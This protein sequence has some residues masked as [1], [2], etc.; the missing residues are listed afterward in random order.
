MASM[1]ELKSMLV[2]REDE[3]RH[4]NELVYSLEKELDEKDAL[5]RHLKN[6]IDKF[7]QVVRPLT[8]DI[9]YRKALPEEPKLLSAEHRQKRQAISAEPVRHGSGTAAVTK[10]PKSGRYDHFVIGIKTFLGP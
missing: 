2:R 7:Q 10:Y 4:R 9:V 5:I 1:Q 6:E 3:L 8:R